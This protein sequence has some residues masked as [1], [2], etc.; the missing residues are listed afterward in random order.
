MGRADGA[1]KSLP[2]TGEG[3]AMGTGI[4]SSATGTTNFYGSK[5]V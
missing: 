3:I 2:M 4:I 5:M 1:E